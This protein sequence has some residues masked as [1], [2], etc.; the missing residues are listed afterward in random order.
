M[1]QIIITLAIILSMPFVFGMIAGENITLEF[2]GKVK[3]CYV[4]D[5]LTNLSDYHID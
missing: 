2:S 5:G 4:F 3:E 1:K